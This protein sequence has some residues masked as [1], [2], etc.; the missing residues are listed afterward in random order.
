MTRKNTLAILL[1]TAIAAAPI[2]AAS[3]DRPQVTVSYSDLDLSRPAGAAALLDRLS[4]AA[5]AVCGGVPDIRNL[6]AMSNFRACRKEAMDRAVASIRAPLV[7]QLY[8]RPD[9]A[10]DTRTLAA[11]N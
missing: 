2:R 1:L 8:G 7:A 3:F 10:G 6:A 5:R 9:L 11:N 4:T